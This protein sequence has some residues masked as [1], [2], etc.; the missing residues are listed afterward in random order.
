MKDFVQEFMIETSTDRIEKGVWRAITDAKEFGKWFPAEMKD[1]FT[2]GAPARGR[3]TYP[4]YE[5][6]TLELYVE[7]MPKSR[8]P[9]K[10]LRNS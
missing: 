9:V 4:G 8:W 5:H 2:P 1:A 3:I 7:R 6:L 10:S